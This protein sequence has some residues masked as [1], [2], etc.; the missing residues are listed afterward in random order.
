MKLVRKE[1]PGRE[2]AKAYKERWVSRATMV[3]LESTARMALQVS[4]ALRVVA[5]SLVSQVYRVIKDWLVCP[6]SL[7]PREVS[8]IRVS[9]EAAGNRDSLEPLARLVSQDLVEKWDLEVSVDSR[10][11]VE[12][13]ELWDLADYKAKWVL[14][15][16]RDHQES[17]VPKASRV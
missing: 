11:I 9:L 1:T 15:V 12:N 5:D 14:K 10:G 17:P 3:Y 8:V 2:G 16:N 13:G 4:L 6:D 7:D